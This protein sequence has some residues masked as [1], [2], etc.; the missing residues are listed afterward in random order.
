MKFR[1]KRFNVLD[2]AFCD[3]GEDVAGPLFDQRHEGTVSQRTIWTAEG[4]C[5]GERGYA[6]AEVRCYAFLGTPE[7]A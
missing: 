7:V 1:G 5:I 6:D 3:G 4:K 2:L